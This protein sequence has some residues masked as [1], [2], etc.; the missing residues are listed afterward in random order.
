MAIFNMSWTKWKD[1][2]KENE[3]DAY[4]SH[5][6]NNTDEA[7]FYIIFFNR[8]LSL[9][10]ERI[11]DEASETILKSFDMHIISWYKWTQMFVLDF[12]FRNV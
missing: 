9:Y 7:A 3:Y 11:R 12:S 10:R 5:H 8:H 6:T 4:R 1:F 2:I